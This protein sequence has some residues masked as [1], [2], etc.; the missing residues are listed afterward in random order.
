[1]FETSTAKINFWVALR[2]LLFGRPSLKN[3][4]RSF[5]LF[6]RPRF[7]ITCED[8]NILFYETKRFW[9]RATV[10]SIQ[11]GRRDSFSNNP[12]TTFFGELSR[13]S[14]SCV[15]VDVIATFGK[16][17]STLYRAAVDGLDTRVV[18]IGSLKNNA[19]PPRNGDNQP[20][21]LVYISSFA[22]IGYR[23]VLQDFRD[24]IF[25]YWSGCPVTYDQ[26]FK[27]EG[28]TAK[29]AARLADSWKIPLLILGKRPSWQTG[30]LNFFRQFLCDFENWSY[31]PSEDQ[32]SSY[33][34]VLTN[35]VLINLDSTLG[36]ELLARGHRVAFFS[37]RM[38]V[39]GYSGI[40]DCHY[41]YPYV[42]EESGP[43]WTSTCSSDEFNRIVSFTRFATNK[44][45]ET[46]VN[47]HKGVLEFDPQNSAFCRLL[48]DIGISN[49]GPSWWD[50]T[51]IPR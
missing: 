26:M 8:N 29:L 42:T 21:R 28:L 12:R 47:H 46:A 50:H 23:K 9:A 33:R 49:R 17:W 3:Y 18:E 32:T 1:M 25:G 13:L 4:Y 44:E 45:W 7:V 6:V 27:A 2:S 10:I 5:L 16:P 36:Y 22:N 31:H 38:E 40:K 11:N 14:T 15:G 37:C 20:S 19:I 35:D 48:T 30:E 41:A 24:E 39:A 43:F 51:E 34:E